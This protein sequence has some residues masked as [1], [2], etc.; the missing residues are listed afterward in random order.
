MYVVLALTIPKWYNSTQ[1]RIKSSPRSSLTSGLGEANMAVPSVTVG[2][3]PL[4]G[5]DGDTGRPLR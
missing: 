1:S 2:G 4:W 5:G 3:G